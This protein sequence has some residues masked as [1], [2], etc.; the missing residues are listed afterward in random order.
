LDEDYYAIHWMQEN[1]EGSPVIVEAAP[2]GRQYEWHSRF[3]IYTG[4]P[5]VVGWQ[6][7]QQQQRVT[8]SNQV[9]QRGVDVD[10]FYN[11]PDKD[12]AVNF[13]RTYDVRYIVVGKLEFAKYTPVDPGIPDGLLKFNQFNGILWKEV[14]RYGNTVI[15][16][17]LP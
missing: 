6:Y 1:I 14:Y 17:V 3:T 10:N 4:L 12:A 9:I 5:G 13:I 16:E 2:A 8:F 15:Y 7:H 11:S